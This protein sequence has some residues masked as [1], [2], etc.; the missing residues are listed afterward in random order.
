MITGHLQEKNGRYYMVLNLKNENN[1]WKPKWIAT[2]LLI[3]GNKKKANTMLQDTIRKYE[4]QQI[5]PQCV[6]NDIL[7]S[8]YMLNWLKLIRNSVE[9]TTFT[10]YRRNIK[11]SIVPYCMSK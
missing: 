8:D 1:K 7:F 6:V 3:K 5:Q 11:G 2:G 4:D 10:S 9:D